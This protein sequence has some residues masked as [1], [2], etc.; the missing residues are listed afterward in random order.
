M[1]TQL[2]TLRAATIKTLLTQVKLDD[3]VMLAAVS[4]HAPYRTCRA[5]LPK[6]AKFLGIHPRTARKRMNVLAE[7]WILRE[8][9]VRGRKRASREIVE[10]DSGAMVQVESDG[11]DIERKFRPGAL[12]HDHGAPLHRKAGRTG[13]DGW[14]VAPDAERAARQAGRTKLCHH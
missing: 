8:S 14:R 9:R 3:L 2:V 10:S 7:F 11:I 4:G 12:A 13:A 1:K 6:L 5:S